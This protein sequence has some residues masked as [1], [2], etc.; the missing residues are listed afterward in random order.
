MNAGVTPLPAFNAFAIQSGQVYELFSMSFPSAPFSRVANLVKFPVAWR[1]AEN[2]GRYSMY[3]RD[4][5]GRNTWLF[6]GGGITTFAI[7]ELLENLYV[8]IPAGCTWWKIVLTA[9]RRSS[10]S[11]AA[12]DQSGWSLFK[13]GSGGVSVAHP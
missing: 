1:G 9:D 10:L 8:K 4:S 2:G 6:S 12:A 7:S 3:L 13:E 5:T 11:R